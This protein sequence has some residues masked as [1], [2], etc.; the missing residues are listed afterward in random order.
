MSCHTALGGLVFA[1]DIV[2]GFAIH[3]MHVSTKQTAGSDLPV[4]WELS[5]HSFGAGLV[6]G[7]VYATMPKIGPT[8]GLSFRKRP[9]RGYAAVRR[10]VWEGIRRGCWRCPQSCKRAWL[11]R[12]WLSK[13][14]NSSVMFSGERSSSRL[15]R[16]TESHPHPWMQGFS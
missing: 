5:L 12:R 10:L 1:I 15:S 16:T 7:A 2:V 14:G 13:P 3:T 6:I 11:A 4:F 9:P 8:L